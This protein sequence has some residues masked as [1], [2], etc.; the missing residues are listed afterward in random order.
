ML[1]E[2]TFTRLRIGVDRP[3]TKEEVVDYVL[4]DFSKQELDTI[5]NKEEMIFEIINEFIK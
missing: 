4:G 2:N 1:G 5:K 3:A